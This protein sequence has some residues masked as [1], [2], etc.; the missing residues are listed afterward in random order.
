M[1]T[2]GAMAA[3]Q[4]GVRA[5]LHLAVMRTIQVALAVLSE[6]LAGVALLVTPLMAARVLR[7]GALAEILRVPVAEVSGCTVT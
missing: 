3:A 2:Q 7:A 5:A 4:L 6:A 1:P